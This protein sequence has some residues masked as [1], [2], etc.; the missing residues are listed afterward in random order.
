LIENTLDEVIPINQEDNLVLGYQINASGIKEAKNQRGYFI[1]KVLTDS[2]ELEVQDG[3]PAS[4]AWFSGVPDIEAGTNFIQRNVHSN[5]EDK[6]YPLPTSSCKYAIITLNLGYPY[7]NVS[8]RQDGQLQSIVLNTIKCENNL[9]GKKVVFL[10]DS[11]TAGT[12]LVNHGYSLDKVYHKIFADR[13]KL[14]EH[15][16]L[17][18]GGSTIATK[19]NA[20]D[21]TVNTNRFKYRVTSSNFADADLVVVFG[22]V[23]DADQDAYPIGD[24]FTITES[25]PNGN[26]GGHS[27]VAPTIVNEGQVDEIAPFGAALHQLI[28]MIYN[29]AP[30]VPILFITPL[31]TSYVDGAKRRPKSFEDNKNGDYMSDFRDAIH[32]VCDFY[33]IPVFDAHLIPQL[34]F[35]NTAFAQRYSFDGLHPNVEGNR[36]IGEALYKFVKDNIAILTENI[37]YIGNID[38]SELTTLWN[39][40]AEAIWVNINYKGSSLYTAFADGVKYKAD[41]N[42]TLDFVKINISTGVFSSIG[43]FNAVVGENIDLY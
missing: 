38:F 23:N 36:L 31:N 6:A 14:S 33:S 25:T 11:I 27:K 9:I 34:N 21:E 43:S 35:C 28:N 26:W 39:S 16:N 4:V 10:G 17:G 30:G 18:V 41:L 2:T 19:T 13:A 22:G 40:T 29:V 15:R 5:I 20:S 42:H 12:A 1:V 3:T 7:D 24:L 37:Y 8:I 32:D